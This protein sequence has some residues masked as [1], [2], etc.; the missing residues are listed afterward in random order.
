MISSKK[1]GTNFDAL[2]DLV[3]FVQLKKI[4]GRV[5]LLVRL[6][7]DSFSLLIRN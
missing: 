6:R 7:A 4:H 1:R 5:L 3:P 2:L